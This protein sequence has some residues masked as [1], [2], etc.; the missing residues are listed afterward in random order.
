MADS[1]KNALESAFNKAKETLS[2]AAET[3]KGLATT[4]FEN[5]QKIIPGHGDPAASAAAA[6]G[7]ANAANN[8]GE[9]AQPSP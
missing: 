6:D 3:T 7:D 5:V 8:T 9:G 4:A 1:A 2:T